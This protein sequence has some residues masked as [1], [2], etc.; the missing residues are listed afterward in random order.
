M[1]ELNCDIQPSTLR[2]GRYHI[3]LPVTGHTSEDICCSDKVGVSRVVASDTTKILFDPVFFG[4]PPTTRASTRSVSRI[5][6]DQTHTVLWC[7]LL[8]PV[9]HLTVCPGSH[10]L[11][12][13]LTKFLLLLRMQLKSRKILQDQ[14]PSGFPQK[15]FN[16]LINILSPITLT[17]TFTFTSWTLST[18]SSTNIRKISTINFT[19]RCYSQFSI[20]SIQTKI[21]TNLFN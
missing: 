10:R 18:H 8:D 12:R 2:R 16:C 3:I 5:N 21:I 15:G 14:S 11:T 7:K 1:V 9:Q 4:Y 6:V 17:S 19:I 13:F 20:P